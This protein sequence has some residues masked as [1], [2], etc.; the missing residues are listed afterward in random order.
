MKLTIFHFNVKHCALQSPN[1][2]FIR[3]FRIF[4]KFDEFNV[5][6]EFSLSDLMKINL[7]DC[8]FTFWTELYTMGVAM[9]MSF[10][11]SLIFTLKANNWTTST[12]LGCL[13]FESLIYE[14]NAVVTWDEH[15]F[16]ST[17]EVQKQK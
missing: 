13:G 12:Q 9:M 4:C 7:G 10:L 2:I 15:I 16:S 8:R 17:W 14:V 5:F 6:S 3:G 11:I 1:F